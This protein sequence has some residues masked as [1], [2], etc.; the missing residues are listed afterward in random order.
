MAVGSS[1]LPVRPW[2]GADWGCV[3]SMSAGQGLCRKLQKSPAGWLRREGT[4]VRQGLAVSLPEPAAV[5]NRTICTNKGSSHP[6]SARATPAQGSPSLRP[7]LSVP[8]LPSSQQT[9]VPGQ[10]CHQPQHQP[11]AHCGMATALLGPVPG[12]DSSAMAPARCYSDSLSLCPC[13]CRQS[14]ISPAEWLRTGRCQGPVASSLG[15]LALEGKGSAASTCCATGNP[16]LPASGPAV[17]S[18]PSPCPLTPA[19]ARPPAPLQPGLAHRS[20]S[21]ALPG[22]AMSPAPVTRPL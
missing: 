12:A 14:Q 21:E 22:P 11:A 3:C 13:P 15:P 20:P 5:K 16:C 7:R 8:H 6:R 18:L 10:P 17:P 2:R 4:G 19:F 1:Q 9:P